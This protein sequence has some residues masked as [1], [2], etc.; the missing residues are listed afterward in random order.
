[1]MRAI[2]EWFALRGPAAAQRG[3]IS[4]AFAVNDQGRTES[5]RAALA[6]RG[7][8]DRRRLLL[9]TAVRAACSGW[10][11][12]DTDARF[13]RPLAIGMASGWIHGPFTLARNTLG[14]PVTQKR[15]WMQRRPS[16]CSS[17][18]RRCVW[19]PRHRLRWSGSCAAAARAAAE[20]SAAPLCFTVVGAV[21]AP[22]SL[23]L[24][25]KPRMARAYR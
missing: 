19:S 4:V 13:P 12:T 20:S 23:W 18:T 9:C 10:R 7:E 2:A 5:V 11:R 15:A 8:I 14:A 24:R 6:H 17:D 3:A 25:S 21:G 1:M 22:A 16:N